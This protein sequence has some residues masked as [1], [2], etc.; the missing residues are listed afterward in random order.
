M[1]VVD[2]GESDSLE[3]L[4]PLHQLVA[5]YKE[6]RL[7]RQGRLPKMAGCLRAVAAVDK[8]LAQRRRPPPGA[9]HTGGASAAATM[10]A[11]PGKGKAAG[12]ERRA[13]RVGAVVGQTR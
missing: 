5:M 12:L 2:A 3:G 7:G 13:K 8:A 1:V 11:V 4:P 6:T 9:K 10:R